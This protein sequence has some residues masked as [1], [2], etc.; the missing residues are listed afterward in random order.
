M[1]GS[2]ERQAGGSKVI[3]LPGMNRFDAHPHEI[4]NKLVPRFGV[5]Q[6]LRCALPGIVAAAEQPH[7][8]LHVRLH[9][10]NPVKV[11]NAGQYSCMQKPADHLHAHSITSVMD[12]P[13]AMAEN[14]RVRLVAQGNLGMIILQVPAADAHS[15]SACL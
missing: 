6:E 1:A 2:E 7:A 10:C 12:V 5:P 13:T 14:Q 9:A 11:L 3:D 15:H 8:E 4:L